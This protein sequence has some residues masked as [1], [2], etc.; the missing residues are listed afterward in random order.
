MDV[1]LQVVN[2]VLDQ[3]EHA[4]RDQVDLLTVAVLVEPF[5]ALVLAAAD[6]VLQ[7]VNIVANQG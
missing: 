1:Q 6:V 2:K 7:L 3:R 4:Q 5:F